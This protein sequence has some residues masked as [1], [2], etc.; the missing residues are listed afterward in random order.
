LLKDQ[1]EYAGALRYH[2]Q[3]LAMRRRLYPTDRYP[4]GHPHL[5]LSLNNL[6]ALL[7]DQGE[8]ARAL[9]YHEQA[10]AMRR[11]LYPTDR[12]P[13]GHPHLA[14]SLSNLGGLLRDQG[15]CARARP[16]Y[17]QALAMW[18]RLYPTDRYPRGH[19][20]LAR[21][22]INLGALLRDQGEY[23]KARRY[24]EQALA[25]NQRLYPTDRYPQ[26]HPLPAQSLDNLGLLLHD[27]G[28]YAKARRYY[29]QAL[30]M[31]Q[32]LYPTDRYPRGHPDLARSLSNLGALLH[33][34]GECAKALPYYEQALAMRQR[35]YPRD[36][37]PQGHPHLAGCLN[38]LG[39]L[40][41]AQG[42]YAQALPYLEKALATYEDLADA[43]LATA[44]EAEALNRLASLPFTRDSYLTVARRVPQTEGASYAHV[45]RGKAAVARALERRH[46]ALAL[47][48]DPAC[49]G[50]ARDLTETR[51]A[52][53]RLL[54]APAGSQ[55]D[56]RERVRKL[57]DR[58][59]DLERRLARQLP[60]FQGLRERDRLSHADLLKKLPARTAFVDFL[61][62]Y[63]IEQDP[64]ARGRAGRKWTAS[65]LAFVL[66]PGQPVRRVELGPA[67][68]VEEAVNEWR[69]DIKAGRDSAAAA[70]LRRR[71][72]APVAEHLP[73]DT[74]AVLLA[75]D[76]ELTALP[77]AALPGPKPGTV[78]LE[79]P[80]TLALVPH[81]RFLL[82][83]LLAAPPP[84]RDAG[85]LLAVGAVQYDKAPRPVEKH[86]DQFALDRGSERGGKSVTYEELP[87]TERELQQVL[88]LA[89][90][91]ETAVRRGTEAGSGR[92]LL[93]L[94]RARW[95]HLAT[96]GF[97]A[98][99]RFRSALQLDEQDYQRR[100][101]V[102]GNTRERIGAG[103]RNP[104]VLSGLVLAGA[105]L[106]ER[107][108]G[109]LTA[110]ALAGLQ[111]PKLDLVVLSACE[112]GLGDVAGG[113]GAFGLQRAFHI[114]G[115]RNVVASLWRVDDEATAALMGLF[116]RKLWREGKPPPQALKEAQLAL[117]RHPEGIPALAKARGPDFDRE[118]R[119]LEEAP[120]PRAVERAGVRQWAGFVVSGIGR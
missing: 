13:Q 77:W 38:N 89:G 90:K 115:A 18:E 87:G 43:F 73:A 6:G 59:E 23:A 47:T 114:A 93:E 70:A 66:R 41:R 110:E 82:D 32:R 104:L 99:K 28:E 65:Y 106:P 91:R 83:R 117:Y 112:T 86:K 74:E 16:Y 44:S 5:A 62:F 72:W 52:L 103:A 19:P 20:D 9:R 42:E 81:G 79:G 40:L 21:S 51:Q 34:Q 84:E 50:L 45:W 17:E 8:Y 15:E 7:K 78:L 11:R 53:A 3:A 46:Q 4:Q 107:D 37:Y 85:L 113:E 116:Y 61:R 26:G 69:R 31:R 80:F 109:V 94:P 92:L 24:Y 48:A 57:T 118:V 27:Q 101:D 55:P 102:V 100:H 96:H 67:Q 105:N 108:D 14:S 75:P 22:L 33:D 56:L 10:L 12:Y 71:V 63:R 49:A 58:K 120:R 64:E 36:R 2:E 35:L 29:E 60:A 54:L 98:D 88:A 1:G 95:V 30:A 76:G 119:R 39:D 111:L 25:M 68:P 97:F